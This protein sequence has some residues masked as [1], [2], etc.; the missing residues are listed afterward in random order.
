MD[1][2]VNCAALISHTLD[3]IT[4]RRW[5]EWQYTFGSSHK[6][7]LVITSDSFRAADALNLQPLFLSHSDIF[8][9]KYRKS[10]SLKI[11]PGNCD[12]L[13]LAIQKKLPD[14]ENYL[15]SEYDVFIPNGYGAI[16]EIDS[17]SDA[18]LISAFYTKKER[19]PNWIYWKNIQIPD[20]NLFCSLM[21]LVRIS[22]S[23]LSEMDKMY[24]HLLGHADAL[25]PS[26]ASFKKM[27]METWNE[28]A[29]R[30]NI[31]ELTNVLCYNDKQI[32]FSTENSIYHPVKR[33]QTENS[34]LEALKW[35]QPVIT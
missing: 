29:K 18:D 9:S 19:I 17:L 13:F 2:F 20:Q 35:K 27:K 23:L 28:L 7:V 4:L 32:R 5:S 24:S 26:I 1:W 30:V 31:P 16:K 22:N 8:L 3:D 25:I 33:T 10:E 15:F 6:T 21:P 34:I 11:V 12:L 14:F